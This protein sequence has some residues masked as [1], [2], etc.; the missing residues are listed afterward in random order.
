MKLHSLLIK[1]T[2]ST[3]KGPRLVKLFT[4]RP[5]LGFSEAQDEPPVQQFELEESSL[6][7]GTTLTLKYVQKLSTALT[8]TWGSFGGC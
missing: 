8:C 6:E 3:G 7:E 2:G 1:A 4:N 5:S